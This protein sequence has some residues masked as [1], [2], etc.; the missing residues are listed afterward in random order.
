ML[1]NK[2]NAFLMVL[3]GVVIGLELPG[4]DRASLALSDPTL[5]FIW[6]S[7][8]ILLAIGRCFD[9]KNGKRKICIYI[10]NDIIRI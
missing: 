2:N 9:S 6:P 1:Q 3:F 8:I 5:V 10:K 4:L 7:S